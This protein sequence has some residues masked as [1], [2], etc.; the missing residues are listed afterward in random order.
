MKVKASAPLTDLM[1]ELVTSE[2]TV[3]AEI[4][5]G[6][7][8]LKDD[9]SAAKDQFKIAQNAIE[10]MEKLI[11]NLEESEQNLDNFVK[12]VHADLL[13]LKAEAAKKP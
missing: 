5:K 1:N 3:L 13:A 8:H 9:T 6:F 10:G 2:K 11:K 4:N 7:S 12:K